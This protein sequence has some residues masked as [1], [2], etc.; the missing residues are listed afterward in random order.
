MEGAPT[1]KINHGLIWF[2]NPELTLYKNYMPKSVLKKETN[3]STELK[4]MFSGSNP[5]SI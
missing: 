2:I 4:T 3:L 1:M 5:K